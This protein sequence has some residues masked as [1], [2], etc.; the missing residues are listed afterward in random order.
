MTSLA[1]FNRLQI[2]NIGVFI[3]RLR[4]SR[5][6]NPRNIDCFETSFHPLLQQSFSQ[7]DF[8]N[9]CEKRGT[10]WVRYHSNHR[11]IVKRHRRLRNRFFLCFGILRGLQVPMLP[12]FLQNTP[13]LQFI[14]GEQ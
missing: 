12:V 14:V 10:S 9:C 5:S 1:T 7:F 2:D 6:A 8:R 13:N 4:Y 3:V 11:Q